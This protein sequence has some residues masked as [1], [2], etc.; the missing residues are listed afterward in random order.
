MIEA[1]TSYSRKAERKPGEW[2]VILEVKGYCEDEGMRGSLETSVKA[3]S[4]VSC[5]KGPVQIH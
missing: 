1:E 3:G 2:C 5:G 4:V